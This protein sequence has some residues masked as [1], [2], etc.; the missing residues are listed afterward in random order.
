MNS[1][2]SRYANQRGRRKRNQAK[3]YEVSI[4]RNRVMEEIKE[5]VIRRGVNAEKVKGG[6]D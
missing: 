1:K 3:D 5:T 4:L 6:G 2:V